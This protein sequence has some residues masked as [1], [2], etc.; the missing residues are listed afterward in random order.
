MKI[1]LPDSAAPQQP[2]ALSPLEEGLRG[3]NS[4]QLRDQTLAQLKELELRARTGMSAGVS[5]DRYRELAALL[6]ACVA[7]QEVIGPVA[8]SPMHALRASAYHD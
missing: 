1:L 3:P 2:E 8:E 6:D 4:A 5:R 7:A